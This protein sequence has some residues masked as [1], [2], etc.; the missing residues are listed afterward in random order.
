MSLRVTVTSE[1]KGSKSRSRRET[2][3]DKGDQFVVVDPKP[4]DLT[5]ARLKLGENRVEDRTLVC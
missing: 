3:S 5:M 1:V 2:E 4:G